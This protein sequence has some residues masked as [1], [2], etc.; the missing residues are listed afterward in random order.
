MSEG[1]TIGVR[2]PYVA[3]MNNPDTDEKDYAAPVRLAKAVS[4]KL[5]PKVNSATLYA[6]D[7]PAETASVIGEIDVEF[8]LDKVTTDKQALIL[9]NKIDSNGVLISSTDD[10]PPYLAL[11]FQ[12]ST[13]AMNKFTWLYKGKFEQMDEDIKTQGEKIDYQTPKVKATFLK[14][15]CD[16][17]WKASVVAGNPGVTQSIID[18]WFKAV[19]EGGTVDLS[20]LKVDVVPLDKATGVAGAADVKFT[21]NKPIKT[22]TV[23]SMSVFLL[24]GDGS[25]VTT[26]VSVDTTS[27]IVTLH[28]T[29]ALAAG[30]Y[31]AVCTTAIKDISN[32]SLLQNSITN[33][34]VA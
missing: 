12:I 25:T 30:T 7:G 5:S 18:N 34:T 31:L 1:V 28:P 6:D 22:D 24:K 16:N 8:E 13:T 32:L 9:G 21:F 19:Y 27:K 33:F 20:E 15:A 26:T 11:G 4:L 3:I 10:T 14:R 17:R 23:N 29:A 2:T